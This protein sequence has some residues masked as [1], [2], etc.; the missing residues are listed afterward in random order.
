MT[1][2][3]QY[4]YKDQTNEQG[5]VGGFARSMQY[6]T[7]ANVVRALNLNH[8]REQNFTQRLIAQRANPFAQPAEETDE[9]YNLAASVARDLNLS[10]MQ[11]NELRR[12]TRF[13]ANGKYAT[14]EQDVRDQGAYIAKRDKTM[15]G[16]GVGA[17]LVAGLLDP[18]DVGVAVATGGTVG[19]L[20]K[21]A[22]LAKS[23]SL[24]GQKP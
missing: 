7:T 10:P 4:G 1:W 23:T 21:G 20:S 2:V 3:S 18:V 14:F 11:F 9:L 22:R 13:L 12:D 24:I 17:A 5:F 16:V 8:A 6:G 19:A 15:E